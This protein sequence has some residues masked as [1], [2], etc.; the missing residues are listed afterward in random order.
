MERV[1]HKWRLAGDR[2]WVQ[3]FNLVGKEQRADNDVDAI[4]TLFRSQTFILFPNWNSS[5][6]GRKGETEA[7]PVVVA[8]GGDLRT[9]RG[10]SAARPH[11]HHKRGSLQ[12]RLQSAV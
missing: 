9:A 4:C 10:G 1:H 7:D 3:S 6:G 11:H 12:Q 8:L 5:L 2:V